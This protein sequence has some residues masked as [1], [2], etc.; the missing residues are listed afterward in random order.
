MSQG[1]GPPCGLT[2]IVTVVSPANLI[3]VLETYRYTV[4]SEEGVE[5]RA[6]H[7]ALWDAS[8]QGEG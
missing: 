6:Q 2:H 5:E 3:I 8:I 1:A 7:T 4:T